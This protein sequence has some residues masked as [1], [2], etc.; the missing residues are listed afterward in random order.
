MRMISDSAHTEQRAT[1]AKKTIEEGQE[2]PPA[3]QQCVQP[4]VNGGK[5]K[6]MHAVCV[7]PVKST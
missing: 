5:I 2:V 1:E 6:L 4:T 3:G 7:Y